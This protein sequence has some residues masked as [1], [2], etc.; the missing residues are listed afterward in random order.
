MSA[1]CRGRWHDPESTM[2]HPQSQL[3][4]EKPLAGLRKMTHNPRRSQLT[5]ADQQMAWM[6]ELADEEFKTTIINMKNNLWK[7]IW[8]MDRMGE[9]MEILTRETGTVEKEWNESYGSKT[10][11][12]LKWKKFDRLNSIMDTE[13]KGS[14]NMKILQ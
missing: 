13:E 2:C 11:Q 6:L 9:K 8:K 3:Y 12:Y 10:M 4:S 5:E 7:Q 14:V 1:L